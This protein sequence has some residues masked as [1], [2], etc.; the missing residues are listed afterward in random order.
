LRTARSVERRLCAPKP[1][2]LQFVRRLSRLTT[3]ILGAG[4]V[5]DSGAVVLCAHL[6]APGRTNSVIMNRNARPSLRE[7]PPA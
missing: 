5:F 6:V 2:L 3:R 7:L 4:V 1:R